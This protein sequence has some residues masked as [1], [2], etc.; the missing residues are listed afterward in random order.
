MDINSDILKIIGHFLHSWWS[1]IAGHYQWID[2]EWILFIQCCF[3]LKEHP[4]R[5]EREFS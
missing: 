4:E 5:D 3:F 2:Q 1:F